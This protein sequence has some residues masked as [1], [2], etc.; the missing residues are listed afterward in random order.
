[1]KWYILFTEMRK[2][3]KTTSLR[4]GGNQREMLSSW[5]SGERSELETH[6]SV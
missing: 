4:G 5:N 3:G 1:M 6:V 2:P